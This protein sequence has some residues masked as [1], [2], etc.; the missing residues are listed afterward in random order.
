M[1][2]N[3]MMRLSSG[4]L[5]AVLLS[6][7][8]ISGT[9]AKYVTRGEGTDSARVAKF[10]VTVTGSSDAFKQEYSKTDSKYAGDLTVKAV[11]NV[12]APGTNGT[13][14]AFSINGTPEV[15]VR[16][17]YKIKS[18]VIDDNW[19]ITNEDGSVTP[20]CPLIFTV[21]DKDYYIDG[22]TITSIDD[23]ETAL[24]AENVIAS[25]DFAPGTDLSSADAVKDMNK[26]I[27]WRWDFEAPTVGAADG[28]NDVKDTALGNWEI[29]GGNA[30]TVTIEVTATVTQID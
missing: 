7:C 1:K 9:F 24:A 21:G 19:K 22:E 25:V 6:T 13:V 27:S 17:S 10:G 26:A 12:V 15:A 16:V 18:V 30:P 5:V 3:I 29:S 11:T 8:A 20:Y 14:A 4:L 28:Q 2:K 23:L